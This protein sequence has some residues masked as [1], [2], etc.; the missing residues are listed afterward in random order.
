MIVF[1]RARTHFS[2][3]INELF[4]KFNSKYS[5]IPPGQTSY[6]QP[7]DVSINKPFKS[8]IYKMYTEFQINNNN[9]KKPTR[10]NIIQF[11]HDI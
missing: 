10:E 1:D 8:A 3:R 9:S 5:L 11:I 2:E 6:I 4:E 7:L